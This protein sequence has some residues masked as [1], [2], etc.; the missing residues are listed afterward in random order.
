[1][2]TSD[3]ERSK[4]I[5]LLR[6]R[7]DQALKMDKNGVSNIED[8]SFL[9]FTLLKAL[10]GEFASVIYDGDVKQEWVMTPS[11]MTS[12]EEKHLSESQKASALAALEEAR[13]LVKG[14]KKA[15]GARYDP[16]HL[17]QCLANFCG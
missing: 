10:F 12:A 5:A 17:G 1:M 4:S 16:T 7:A 6:L 14:W 11:P 15:K 3:S 13:D 9:M 2:S 8:W